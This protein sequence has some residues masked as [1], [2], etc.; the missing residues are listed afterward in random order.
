MTSP[1]LLALE[2]DDARIAV[3]FRG[4]AEA[5]NDDESGTVEYVPGGAII[6][7]RAPLG[8]IAMM[9][10]PDALAEDVAVNIAAALAAGNRVAI[11]LIGLPDRVLTGVLA[12]LTGGLDHDEFWILGQDRHG[13]QQL[14]HDQVIVAI[15]AAGVRVGDSP[16][17]PHHAGSPLD[18]I[19]RYTQ[20]H[21]FAVTIDSCVVSRLTAPQHTMKG[22]RS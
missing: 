10:A 14:G 1:A 21:R 13:W 5:L 9:C 20:V 8:T 6:E 18:L 3:A 16:R 17:Q 12:T 4:I 19:R 2:L 22:T 7:A 11:G 15:S